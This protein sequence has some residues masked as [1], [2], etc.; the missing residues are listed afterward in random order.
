M[1]NEGSPDKRV[2]QWVL[3][4]KGLTTKV[5]TQARGHRIMLRQYAWDGSAWWPTEEPEVWPTSVYDAIKL[6][7]WF[8]RLPEM[9][10]VRKNPSIGSTWAKQDKEVVGLNI[11]TGLTPAQ[12]TDTKREKETLTC[13]KPSNPAYPKGGG[14]S[15]PPAS[16][17]VTK[18][19]KL[20]DTRKADLK[21]MWENSVELAVIAD[22][23]AVSERDV[24]EM[25]LEMGLG[26]RAG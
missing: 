7:T 5:T 25:A 6:A 18:I 11:E 15:L 8:G 2:A 20:T 14:S 21:W 9:G 24:T 17:S 10:R 13:A 3:F 1:W 12:P 4:D 22:T 19:S 23:F 16:A 26:K